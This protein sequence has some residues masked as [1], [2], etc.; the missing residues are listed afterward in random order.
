M[1]RRVSRSRSLRKTSSLLTYGQ[2]TSLLTSVTEKEVVSD[3]DVLGGI[4]AAA[5]RPA[6]MKVS[7]VSSWEAVH[8]ASVGAQLPA[9]LARAILEFRTAVLVRQEGAIEKL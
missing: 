8:E 6:Y 5:C 4:C 7:T 3:V 9:A 1:N 2:T